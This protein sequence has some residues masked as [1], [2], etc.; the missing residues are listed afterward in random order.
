MPVTLLLIDEA[1]LNIKLGEFGLAVGSQ[2]LI[3]EAAHDL[4]VAIE[5]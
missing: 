4:I 1:Q 2:V 5:P 3:A